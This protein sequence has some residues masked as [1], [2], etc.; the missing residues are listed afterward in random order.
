[1]GA[2]VVAQHCDAPCGQAAGNV[3]ERTVATDGFVAILRAG[4]VHQHHGREWSF[5]LGQGQGAGQCTARLRHAEIGFAVARVGRRRRCLGG[6]GRAQQQ[7]RDFVLRV[8]R[9]LRDHRASGELQGYFHQVQA[10]LLAAVCRATL[11]QFTQRLPQALQLVGRHGR[12][13]LR[14]Q[15]G[16]GI[17]DP[18]GLEVIEQACCDLLRFASGCTGG[19]QGKGNSKQRT[20]CAH[21]HSSFLKTSRAGRIGAGMMMLTS[22]Q[23][24]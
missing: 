15:H 13:H 10:L 23:P 6:R 12:G 21:G 9:H 16:F 17:G 20:A 4:A 5:A 7:T 8:H 24:S 19:Q 3:Q 1:M 14:G 18:P 2:L 22:S 11:L